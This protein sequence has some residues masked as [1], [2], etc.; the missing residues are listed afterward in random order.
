[1]RRW[2]NDLR[3]IMNKEEREGRKKER[4]KAGKARGNGM[5]RYKRLPLKG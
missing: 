2:R 1:V 4:K 5:E 3:E